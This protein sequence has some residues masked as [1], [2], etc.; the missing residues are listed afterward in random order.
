MPAGTGA[1]ATGASVSSLQQAMVTADTA[2]GRRV[3]SLD[4]TMGDK[5]GSAPSMR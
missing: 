1:L 5:I 2:L 4:A 3:D